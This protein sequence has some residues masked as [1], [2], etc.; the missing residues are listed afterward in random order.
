MKQFITVFSA[1]AT[2]FLT[3]YPY[4]AQLLH[5]RDKDVLGPES[6]IVLYDYH[7]KHPLDRQ[8]RMIVRERF[9][10]C[11]TDT[12]QCC[13][14]LEDLHS[15]N[16]FGKS[17]HPRY[18]LLAKGGLLAGLADEVAA[19]GAKVK[20]IEYRYT[21][22]TACAQMFSDPW[23]NPYNFSAARGVT[24]A[25]IELEAANAVQALLSN[26]IA[27]SIGKNCTLLAQ[28][29]LRA[30]GACIDSTP[31][32]SLADC[33]AH[34]RAQARIAYLTQLLIADKQLLEALLLLAVLSTD[35]CG[36]A[37]VMAGGTHCA[38]LVLFL[39]G[40]G[41]QHVDLIQDSLTFQMKTPQALSPEQLRSIFCRKS[42]T[43]SEK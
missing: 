13:L 36:Q 15:P 42:L 8:Y 14:V 22:V 18:R 29:G 33:C 4:R 19:I 23:S 40:H 25:E 26:P 21:R 10:R 27:Q 37:V 41:Y 39:L 5:K 11:T 43:N 9:S 7:P 30:L 6:V 20:N 38:A 35:L 28:E 34:Y 1:I 32:H 17:G 31:N 16:M 24:I 3:G 12:E 2:T